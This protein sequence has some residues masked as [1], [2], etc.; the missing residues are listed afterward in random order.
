M[1][2]GQ[3]SEHACSCY[4]STPKSAGVDL[5]SDH[6]NEVV[7]VGGE[8]V[9]WWCGGGVVSLLGNSLSRYYILFMQAVLQ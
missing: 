8:V 1:H 3:R 4:S 2:S 9:W 6:D 7:V 5:L